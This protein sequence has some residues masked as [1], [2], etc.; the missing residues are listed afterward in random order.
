LVTLRLLGE[1]SAR[2]KT[3]FE[4]F[5]EVSERVLGLLLCLEEL[6]AEIFVVDSFLV[7]EAEAGAD[8]LS[9]LPDAFN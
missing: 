1:D 4:L 5:T 7:D 2:R 9:G 6:L 8:L 3:C